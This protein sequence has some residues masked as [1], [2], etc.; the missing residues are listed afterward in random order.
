MGNKTQEN[1]QKSIISMFFFFLTVNALCSGLQ[2]LKLVSSV[3]LP[4]RFFVRISKAAQNV[5]STPVTPIG[6][7]VVTGMGQSVLSEYTSGGEVK[8]KE[9]MRRGQREQ[10]KQG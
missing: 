6:A 8:E 3:C 1:P 7:G 5:Y 10:S 9:R 2:L 4:A